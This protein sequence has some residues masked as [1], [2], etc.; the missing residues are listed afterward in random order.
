MRRSAHPADPHML[1]R[2][3]NNRLIQINNSPGIRINACEWNSE[4][5]NRHFCRLRELRTKPGSE[6]NFLARENAL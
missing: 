6:S 2:T 3:Q 1:L 4:P 5:R